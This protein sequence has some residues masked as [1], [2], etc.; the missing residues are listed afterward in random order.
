MKRRLAW[1]K[2]NRNQGIPHYGFAI[3]MADMIIAHDGD[4]L[5]A[6]RHAE[7]AD[8]DGETWSVPKTT[9]YLHLQD[10]RSG[11]DDLICDQ[12]ESWVG[13]LECA[14]ELARNHDGWD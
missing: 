4:M 2:R 9:L 14:M 11:L 10:C 1:L 3:M 8:P 5:A 12:R 13:R 6:I 7:A